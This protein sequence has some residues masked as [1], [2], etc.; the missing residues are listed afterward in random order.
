M[1]LKREAKISTIIWLTAMHGVWKSQKKV[2]S[3]VQL[4]VNQPSLSN[5][6]KFFHE[7]YMK[8]IAGTIMALMAVYVV[9]LRE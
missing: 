4:G 8:L 9:L 1:Q 5:P 7:T 2:F 6:I 3:F